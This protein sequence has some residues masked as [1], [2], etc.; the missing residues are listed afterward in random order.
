MRVQ[1]D[2]DRPGRLLLDLDG[3]TFM[4]STGLGAI[5]R[6]QQTANRHGYGLK[7][8]YEGAAPQVLRLFEL[9]GVADRFNSE[10]N[11]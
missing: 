5:I 10:A 8:R 2:G 6:A 7:L 1:L 11:T 4:D 9:A 3:V